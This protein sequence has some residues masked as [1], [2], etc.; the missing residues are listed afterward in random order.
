MDESGRVRADEEQ[1]ELLPPPLARGARKQIDLDKLRIGDV[2]LVRRVGFLN[3]LNPITHVM[4]ATQRWLN[5]VD[6]THARWSHVA[7]YVGEGR[8]VEAKFSMGRVVLRALIETFTL[9]IVSQWPSPGGVHLSR[10]RDYYR[11]HAIRIRRFSG[12]EIL[13]DKSLHGPLGPVRRLRISVAALH[14]IG[15]PY[16]VNVILGFI[17]KAIAEVGSRL[18]E[19][20]VKRERVG[21]VPPKRTRSLREFVICSTF[22]EDCFSLA[23]DS[24]PGPTGKNMHMT[25]ALLSALD[26]LEDVRHLGWVEVNELEELT[27]RLRWEDKDDHDAQFVRHALCAYM[28]GSLEETSLRSDACAKFLI[29][30]ISK[31][32]IEDAEAPRSAVQAN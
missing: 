32:K 21:S 9:G 25:P 13:N 15:K 24:L 29:E 7:V 23:T 26:G 11:T 6:A 16:G 28:D 4:R 10:L 8:I 17:N 2:V 30:Y 5:G 20:F 12:S 14:Q 3:S 18:V 27:P 22:Y 1:S 19:R 31:G